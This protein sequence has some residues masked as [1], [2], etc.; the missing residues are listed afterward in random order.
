[1]FYIL[2]LSST[3]GNISYTEGLVG[4]YDYNAVSTTNENY[5]ITYHII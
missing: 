4:Y 5:K 1:M 2:N 3:P